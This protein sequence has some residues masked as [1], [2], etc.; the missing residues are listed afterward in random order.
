MSKIKSL[1]DI[2]NK[3]PAASLGKRANLL[4]IKKDIAQALKDT[5]DQE[6]KNIIIA[7]SD[8]Y[9]KMPEG[10]SKLVL[11]FM[12]ANIQSEKPHKYI[13]K[14][15]EIH[16]KNEERKKQRDKEEGEKRERERAERVRREQEEEA[17]AQAAAEEKQR[18]EDEKKA[19]KGKRRRETKQ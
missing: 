4:E 7:L 14:I 12:M 16:E 6:I 3:Y 2:A 17:R 5:P 1:Q 8:I 15:I 10:D 9:R 19:N 13:D 18:Q 11:A